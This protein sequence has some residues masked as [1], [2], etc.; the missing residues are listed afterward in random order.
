MGC[1]L[2]A[3]DTIRTLLIK[4]EQCPNLAHRVVS[5]LGNN[6]SA[7]GAKRTLTRRQP[8]RVHGLVAREERALGDP[9]TSLPGTLLSPQHARA[10]YGVAFNLVPRSDSTEEF[11]SYSIGEPE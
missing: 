8:G 9:T 5:L 11:V 6:T 3:A 4:I 2:G 10:V 7:I 1:G